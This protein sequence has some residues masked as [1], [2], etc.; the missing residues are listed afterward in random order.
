MGVSGRRI[1]WF[2]AGAALLVA[3]FAVLAILNIP[4]MAAYACPACFDL[5][6]ADA[7]LFVD[8]DMTDD[9]VAAVMA[10]VAEA[11]GRVRG[12]YGDFDKQPVLLVC[13]TAE[14]DKRLGGKG[15]KARA[16]GSVFI[17]VSP[18]GRNATILAHELAHIENHARVGD[19]RSALGGVPAWFDE[20]IAVIVSR[21]P[22]YLELDGDEV[23]CLVE[24]DGDLPTTA[25][26]WSKAAGKQAR[27]LYA[28]AACKVAHW[29]DANGGKDGLIATLDR[30]G[31]GGSFND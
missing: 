24:P 13:G 8:A 15:A 2:A 12:F 18:A 31:E 14:C 28:M 6:R 30:L 10:A 27:P 26:G 20:G 7:R 29:M 5:K 1:R 22:R 23:R 17:R 3:A 16:Y 4:A 21:D 9:E 11:R 19:F 25:R